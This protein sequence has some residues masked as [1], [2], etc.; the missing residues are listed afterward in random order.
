MGSKRGTWRW[1]SSAAYLGPE[2]L[3]RYDAAVLVNVPAP[4][5]EVSETLRGFV[6][7]LGRGLVVVGGDQAYGL[8]DYQDT[9]LEDLLPVQSNPDDLIRRQPLTEVLVIDTSGSMAAC[10]CRDET[11]VEGGVNKTDISRAGAQ[12]AIEALSSED[13]V[14]VVAVSS[15]TRWVLPGRA[16]AGSDRSGG[17]VG[18]AESPG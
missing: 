10:H 11:F 15:G 4:S 17:G 6:E 1:T 13:R 18:D 3:L 12:L 16:T 7:D 9:Q 5:P 2:T 14:G 8:G